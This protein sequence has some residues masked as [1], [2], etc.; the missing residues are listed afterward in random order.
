MGSDDWVLP[1][2]RI[3]AL[4]FPGGAFVPGIMETTAKFSVSSQ[5]GEIGGTKPMIGGWSA[6][7]MT[8]DIYHGDSGKCHSY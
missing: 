2:T 7:E 3:H 5:N 4:G 8:A 1:Q 6:Y